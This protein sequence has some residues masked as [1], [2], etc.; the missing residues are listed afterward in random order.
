MNQEKRDLIEPTGAAPYIDRGEPLPRSYG[1]TMIVAMVRD[2]EHLF[3]YWDVAP[4]LR[5][6][7]GSFVL[8]IHCLS[9]GT[10]HENQCGPEPQSWHLTVSPNCTYRLELCERLD[11]GEI[12]RLAA[13]NEV[14][15]P[16]RWAGESGAEVP[17]EVTQ[18]EERPDARQAHRDAS[19]TRLLRRA[20]RSALPPE[21]ELE[22]AR[23]FFRS[24][25]ACSGGL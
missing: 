23:S 13:S 3:A 5:V 2:P 9:D 15:T 19:A 11:S 24:G 6:A 18:A 10:C 17:A 25:R 21:P 12:R 16:L 4:E 8:R 7:A 14:T 1:E 22:P 20:A